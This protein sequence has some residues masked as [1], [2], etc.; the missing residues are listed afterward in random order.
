MK[1]IERWSRRTAPVVPRIALV[2]GTLA[3]LT[4]GTYMVVVLKSTGRWPDWAGFESD[5]GA[6]GVTALTLAT[7][8]KTLWDWLQLLLVPILLTLGAAWFN[9]RD[10]VQGDLSH[11]SDQKI[12]DD[13]QQDVALDIYLD[14]LSA[15][16]LD[17][18]LRRRRSLDAG[19][20]VAR[21]RTLTVLRRFSGERGSARKA[22]VLRFLYESH[23]LDKARPSVNMSAA[24]FSN[25]DLR[26]A[27]L[28]GASLRGIGLTGALL[29][30]ADLRDAELSNAV[31][32][33]AMLDEATL[34]RAV[35]WKA[36]LDEANLCGADLRG[37]MMDGATFTKALFYTLKDPASTVTT[38]LLDGASLRDADLRDAVVTDEQLAAAKTLKD[39]LLPDKAG[40]ALRK[41]VLDDPV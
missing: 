27:T 33:G 18:H 35:L 37:A 11:A 13:R 16:L 8:N 25:A 32:I 40:E 10:R 29:S 41:R 4:L 26:A 28:R 36:Q 31:L 5:P 3:V 1:S 6:P 15:L 24:D 12:E 17:R 7:P 22:V 23:L 2:T 34:P 39:A 19:W 30:G 9:H 38:A 14:R 20:D 21:A